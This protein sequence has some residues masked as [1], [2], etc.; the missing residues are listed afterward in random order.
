MSNLAKTQQDEILVPQMPKLIVVRQD[1]VTVDDLQTI[2]RTKDGDFNVIDFSPFGLAVFTKE[3]LTDKSYIA[4]FVV[5]NV[6]IEQIE[7]KKVRSE[8]YF[9]NEHD[10]Y[11]TAFAI[12]GNPISMERAVAV[13]K[14]TEVLSE[15]LAQV[16]APQVPD[17]FKLVSY[18]ITNW[19][20]K[21]QSLVNSLEK[22]SFEHSRTYLEPYEA[23]VTEMVAHYIESNIYPLYSK[24]QHIVEGLDSQTVKSSFVFFREQVGPYL[25]QSAYANRAYTKPRGYAGDFEMMKSVYN[26]EQRG[27]SLFGRCVERYFVNVPESQAVR[28]RGRYL[29]GKIINFIQSNPGRPH[30]FLSLACGPA[31]EIQYLIQENPELLTEDVE[32][33]FVDQDTEALKECQKRIEL[34]GRQFKVKAKFRFHNWAVKNIIENGLQVPELSMI[35]T[36]G[37]FDYLSDAVASYA[38]QRLF[39]NVLPGGELIIGNFDI[40]APNRFGMSLVTDWH[41]IYRTPRD[42]ER[43]FGKLGNFTVEKE[44]L[45]INLFASLK[46]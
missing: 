42:L 44:S 20:A 39:T 41:L 22:S 4:S 31:M 2:I 37:L 40:S 26:N 36:A 30:R 29:Q 5:Q 23:V 28:N 33:Y 14:T 17:A 24:I 21:L 15:H 34:L 35:Y 25:Y 46:K 12:T 9:H 7:I 8:K 45:G 6:E 10:G 3:D 11:K 18:E 32:I 27:Q 19:L 16:S 43:L 13:R 38:A 1:R